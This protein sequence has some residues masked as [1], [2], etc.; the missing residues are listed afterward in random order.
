MEQLKDTSIVKD[1][2]RGPDEKSSNSSP[3][4]TTN[5]ER[6]APVKFVLPSPKNDSL[7][8]VMSTLTESTTGISLVPSNHLKR[9]EP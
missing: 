1:K 9:M 7:E 4:K 2:I 5:K 8:T 6:K 3:D